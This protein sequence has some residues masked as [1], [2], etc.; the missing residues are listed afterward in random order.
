[1]VSR[2]KPAADFL[3]QMID[4]VSGWGPN[5]GGNDGALIV[6]LNLCDYND[7][8]PIA[9]AAQYYFYRQKIFKD[10]PW[11]EDLFWFF[12]KEVVKKFPIMPNFASFS[13]KHGGFH[14]L[15]GIESWAMLRCGAYLS[16]PSQPDCL[17]MDFWWRGR[18]IAIDPGT[19]LY[20][21]E[22]PWNNG[23]QA[24]TFHNTV[25]V[26]GLDQ[27]ERGPGFMWLRWHNAGISAQMKK[28]GIE[29]IEGEHDGYCR[30]NNPVRHKRCMVKVKD[31]VWLVI[32]DLWG[33][34]THEFSLQWLLSKTVRK[35]EGLFHKLSYPEGDLWFSA[36]I[37][38][39]NGFDV[40][41]AD[42]LDHADEAS[43]RGWYS[44][45]YGHKERGMS[46]LLNSNQSAPIRVL[47]IFST[48][49]WSKINI[50]LNSIILSGIAEKIAIRL[51]DI[52]S[53]VLLDGYSY[54]NYKI[55]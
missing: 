44:R 52:G 16:R 27:L 12:G 28:N 34:G 15:R 41:F 53:K 36:G 32:D 7:M 43:P 3:L 54:H 20:Y 21:A 49:Q 26:D 37:L 24:T 10:G 48:L 2:L 13:S 50:E 30:L 38:T 29:Y 45:Y 31:V 39:N 5:S 17:H 8:R 55:R 9:A 35:K 14:T 42:W 40:T 6:P 22:E 25:C 46:L 51:G 18:N 23:L 19:Y 33:Q 1:M 11:H 47:T 4:P